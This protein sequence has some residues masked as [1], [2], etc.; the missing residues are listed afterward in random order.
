MKSVSVWK[1]SQRTALINMHYSL[2][3]SKCFFRCHLTVTILLL[4]M[5]NPFF[6][7][8]PVCIQH[9]SSSQL[10][11]PDVRVGCWGQV[12]D[13]GNWAPLIQL[14][15]CDSQLRE[16]P[17]I[18]GLGKVLIFSNQ[19]GA[20]PR[21]PNRAYEHQRAQESWAGQIP[22]LWRQAQAA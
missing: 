12:Q 13:R 22:V 8:P 15:S 20:N 9:I 2:L 19:E 4:L 14:A 1:K 21:K 6:F 18:D 16:V 11:F 10:Q 7:F 3:C 17:G 5:Q